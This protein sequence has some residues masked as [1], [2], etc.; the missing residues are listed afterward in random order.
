M[1]MWTGKIQS[2]IHSTIYHVLS[3]R[4]KILILDYLYQ[5]ENP[6]ED[7]FIA[8]DV[9]YSEQIDIFEIVMVIHEIFK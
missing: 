3:H 7:Q 5:D 9:N 6:A 8:G 4:R 2:E 1:P